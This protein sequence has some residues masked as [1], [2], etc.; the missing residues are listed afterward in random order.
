M[1][2]I[3]N[4]NNDYEISGYISMPE[5]TRASR[6]HMIT[7][8]N[9]RVIRNN[10]LNK[11]INDAYH[12]YKEDTR[13]PIV[14]INIKCDPELIDVNIHPSKLDIKFGNFEDLKN[15]ITSTIID[16]IR[17]KVLIPKIEVKNNTEAPRYEN[18][19][20]DFSNNI[21][22][23]KTSE[24]RKNLEKLINNEVVIND[25]EENYIEEIK[26]E[27]LPKLYPVGLL[28]GTYIACENEN[29]IYLIDQHAAKERINYEKYSY[30]LGHP[31]NN[32]C[33]L[34]IPIIIELPKNE[35]IIVKENFNILKSIN[36]GIEEFG[37]NSFRITSHPTWFPVGNE[38]EVINKIIEL[39]IQ[40]EKD[41]TIEKF[42]D[43]LA[44]TIS[45]KMSK[46]AN[47]YSSIEEMEKLISDLGNCNN[48]YHCPHGRPTIITFSIY[49]LEK[50]FK[51]SI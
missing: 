34:L 2:T 47:T 31:N 10:E 45:C 37:A 3:K 4:E 27:K 20:I 38:K 11:T 30:I 48:P 24:Y 23:E 40:K 25:I 50:M 33:S 49:E 8:V 42:N 17:E 15:L 7:L 12:T 41:F 16:S 43:R 39:V 32:T 22:L 19:S 5:V 21:I 29:G 44:M 9:N 46:K 26:K 51:R 28:L 1:I 14:V 6:S 13:Y 36:V 18:I 35:F